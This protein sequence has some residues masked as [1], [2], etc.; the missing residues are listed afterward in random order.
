[1]KKCF[2]CG[3]ELPDDAEY[4]SSCGVRQTEDGSIP[5]D[6]PDAVPF[7]AEE[8]IDVTNAGETVPEVPEA[9]PKKKR[10]KKEKPLTVDGDDPHA[11]KN[12]V[13]CLDGKYRWVYEVNLF[14]DPWVLWTILKIFGG[15]IVAGAVIS[16]IVELF[17][18]HNYMFILQM[19]GI[20]CGIFLVLSI[21]GY[22]LYAA[23]MGGNYCVLYTMDDK[24]ILSEQQPKQAK[25]AEII[26]DLLVLAGALS[27]NMTTV[28]I[29]MTSARKTSMHTS[30]AGTKKLKGVA[31]KGLIK[32]DALFS[33]D[34]TYC[35]PEDFNFVWNYVKSRCESAKI[36][37][38][39]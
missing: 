26:A 33:H 15:I 39:F 32:M 1:M 36:T 34:R 16:F 24:G 4:C 38:K 19:V 25:K 37:E 5:K 21:L 7:G 22:L 28:G 18:D 29:G 35:E 17:G 3:K 10:T 9:Q 8:P 20:M 12:V 23:I 27:G 30:F 31:R 14:K 6:G 13:L 2:N 11:S